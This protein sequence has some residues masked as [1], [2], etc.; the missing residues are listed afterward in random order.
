MKF[1][2]GVGQDPR[3]N[4]FHFGV[5]LDQGADPRPSLTLQDRCFSTF[6]SIY[7]RM[8]QTYQKRQS[9]MVSV[10]PFLLI[11]HRI[12]NQACLFLIQHDQND[13]NIV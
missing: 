1:C 11:S 3:K 7:Q 4:P 10:E 8:I 12:Y 6:S 9:C 5:Y 13:M 2:G